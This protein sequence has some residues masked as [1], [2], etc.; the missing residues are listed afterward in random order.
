VGMGIEKRG[1]NPSSPRPSP[2]RR[3]WSA[4]GYRSTRN[5]S[6]CITYAALNIYE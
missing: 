5:W 6:R 4:A 2:W 3:G 1:T